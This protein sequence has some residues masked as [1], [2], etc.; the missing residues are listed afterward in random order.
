[1]AED[2]KIVTKKTAAKP[3]VTTKKVVAKATA[4]GAGKAPIKPPVSAKKTVARP[5]APKPAAA[6]AAK[7][8]PAP[9]PVTASPAPRMSNPPPAKKTVSRK[10][11]AKKAPTPAASPAPAP[12]APRPQRSLEEKPVSFQHLAKVTPEQRLDMIRE[13]A[14]FKAEKRNFAPGNDAEDWAEA[15]REIDELIAKARKIYGA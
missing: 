11:V 7:P 10:T 15:E 6:P 9:K 13:A 3:A 8:T 12:A 4:T 5:A 2:K 1:M 14:Y